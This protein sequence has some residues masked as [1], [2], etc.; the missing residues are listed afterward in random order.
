MNDAAIVSDGEHFK[1]IGGYFEHPRQCDG[2]AVGC[3]QFIDGSPLE[4]VH[5]QE[6]F[7]RFQLAIIQ[8]LH[9]SRMVHQIAGHRFGAK[10]L[11]QFVVVCE[12]A[13]QDLDRD[14][15]VVAIVHSLKH[16]GH[17]AHTQDAGE[18][19]AICDEFAHLLLSVEKFAT[20]TRT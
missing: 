3:P 2:A 11:A 7:A 14:G 19:P 17:A 5:D 15:A 6:W 16:T 20:R 18:M 8:E 13:M 12:L 4:V 1:Y 10:P 9:S